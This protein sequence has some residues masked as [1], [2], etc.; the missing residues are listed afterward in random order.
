M[1][2]FQHFFLHVEDS[3]RYHPELLKELH[4]NYINCLLGEVTEI[5]CDVLIAAIIDAWKKCKRAYN[6]QQASKVVTF[7]HPSI[8]FTFHQHCQDQHCLDLSNIGKG[9]SNALVDGRCTL[10]FRD[11]DVASPLGQ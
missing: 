4:K 10:A 11:D 8:D 1:H 5:R 9:K 2:R 3:S 7:V 6:R